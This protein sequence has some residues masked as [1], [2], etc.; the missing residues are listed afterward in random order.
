MTARFEEMGVL[1]KKI[2][3][4]LERSIRE[5]LHDGAQAIE[6]GMTDCITASAKEVLGANTEFHFLR[7]QVL[8]VCLMS[9]LAALA[10]WLGTGD[11]LG[12]L[13]DDGR[14]NYLR[15]VLQIPASGVAFICGSLYVVVWALDYWKSVERYVSY[16][17]MFTLKILILLALLLHVL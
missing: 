9:I 4:T 1:E 11:I 3:A 8:A 10:Y 15:A 7:G 5:I 2:D 14:M 16:K 13:T 17:A 12:V 6:R